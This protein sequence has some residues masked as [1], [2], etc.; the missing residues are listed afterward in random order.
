[1]KYMLIRIVLFSAFLILGID[2][3]AQPPNPPM[4]PAA[5]PIDGGLGVLVVA[6]AFL[7]GK[8]V[9]DNQKKKS[10]TF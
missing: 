6:G 4:D 10:S 2:A 3:N 9:W 5:V 1:M 8:K 7:G